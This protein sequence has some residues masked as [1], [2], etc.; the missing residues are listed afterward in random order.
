METEFVYQI[1]SGPFWDWRVS[2]DLFVGGAGVGALF[3]AVLL[4]EWFKARYRRICHTAAWLSPILV[5]LGLILIMS[6]LG[7]PFH[8]FL[9]YTTFN[10]AAPLWWGG[11]FQPL[12]IIGSLVYALKWNHAQDQDAGRIWLGRILLPLALIVGAYHGLL[13]S[14]MV[15]HPLWV[16]GPTVVAALLGFAST[17]IAIVMLVHLVRMKIAGR[18]DDEEHT[19]AYL[20]DMRVVRNTLV[21]VLVLQLGTCFLWWLSLKYGALQDQQALAAAN[22]A[23]GPMFWWL[24]LGLGLV[25]PLALGAI[26]VLLGE[27]SHRRLQVS[28]IG[29]TSFLILVGGFFFRTALVLGGQV[30]LP[31]H[32][33]F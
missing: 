25:L 23:Y 6:K 30:H 3:F 29:L 19:A 8:L 33:P 28:M 24:G 15:S 7:R 5:T 17:G 2:L 31:T 9:V 22:G 26:T 10:P 21:G 1:Q 12:L 18:L 11:I 14:T 27:A 20:D 4:D 32:I 16:A 13:L